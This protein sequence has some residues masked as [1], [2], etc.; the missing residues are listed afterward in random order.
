MIYPNEKCDVKL[1]GSY[2]EFK[3][4]QH[5]SSV[6]T[7]TAYLSHATLYPSM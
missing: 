1:N 6:L 3:H 5:Y 2:K 4:K 7:R